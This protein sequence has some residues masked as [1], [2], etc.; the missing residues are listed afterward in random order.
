MSAVA[1]EPM[2]VIRFVIG[3]RSGCA[4]GT[5]TRTSTS[6]ASIAILET[7]YPNRA[8]ARGR[9]GRGGGPGGS[10]PGCL[11]E[12]AYPGP[13]DDDRVPRQGHI[14]LPACFIASS[15]DLQ[16]TANVARS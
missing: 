12:R 16:A 2:L 9:G 7:S 10:R 11:A 14:D 5:G 13:P 3:R 8:L 15:P 1:S 6:A 4:P